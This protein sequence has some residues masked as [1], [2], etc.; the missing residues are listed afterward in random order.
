MISISEE[1]LNASNNIKSKKYFYKVLL[2]F[3]NNT[4]YD[5]KLL[6]D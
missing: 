2:F 3:I 6:I 4:S 1:L 5:N